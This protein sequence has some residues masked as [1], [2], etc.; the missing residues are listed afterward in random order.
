MS[1]S[2]KA[3]IYCRVS[4]KEQVEEGNSLSTQEKICREYAIKH[5]LEVVE[6]FIE[7]GESAKTKD[8][9]E[10]KRLLSFCSKKSNHTQAVIVYKV[11]RLSRNT[12]DYSQLRLFL[13]RYGVEIKSA[14]E[15][16]DNN[17]MGRFI[18][19]LMANIAE[20]DNDIRAERCRQGMKDAVLEGRYVWKAPPGYQNIHIDGKATIA[21][22]EESMLVVKAF[23]M[24]ASRLY[25]PEETRL[26]CFKEGLR[27]SRSQ[28]YRILHNKIYTGV[29]EKFGISL[30]GM[31]DPLVD[32]ATYNA[33]QCVLKRRVRIVR[34]YRKNNPDFP[35]RR[36]V[37]DSNGIKVTGTWSKGKYAAY[38]YYRFIGMKKSF[39]KTQFEASFILFLNSV[40]KGKGDEWYGLGFNEK[41]QLQ[42]S[43]FSE[44]VLYDGRGFYAA[45]T[46]RKI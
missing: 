23:E 42:Y 28:F 46:V 5:G 37:V 17:P 6:I 30:R 41:I 31:F 43:L 1:S 26:F 12:D 3:V 2:K 22:S 15:A 10:L 27:I 35:L 40:E 38:P 4:T 7:S 13:K 19:N 21:P 45:R 34:S 11:D 44:G 32:V 29:I 14:T 20:F 8:R 25:S 39:P 18:E 36:F 24:I 16:F 33:V 9:K